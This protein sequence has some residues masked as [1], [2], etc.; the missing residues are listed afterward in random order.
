[1]YREKPIATWVGLYFFMSID[2]KILSLNKS[3]STMS[4]E[5][6]CIQ[7]KAVQSQWCDGGK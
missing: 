3:F 4:D 6:I 2:D 7:M 5:R 1:M